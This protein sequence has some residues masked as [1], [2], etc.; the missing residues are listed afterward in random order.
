M[1]GWCEKVGIVNKG[2][3]VDPLNCEKVWREN[4]RPRSSLN[5][6]LSAEIQTKLFL[7]WENMDLYARESP[8][9][10]QESA[11]GLSTRTLTSW[12]LHSSHT[13]CLLHLISPYRLLPLFNVIWLP[14][15]RHPPKT[16]LLLFIPEHFWLTR[17]Y[18]PS[19][20][21]STWPTILPTSACEGKR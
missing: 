17:V 11:G 6:R 7:T 9:S 10:S 20:H 16:V 21:S 2:A 19:S 15:P 1:F 5:P 18:Q 8:F 13:H 4:L 12:R 3:R 14:E